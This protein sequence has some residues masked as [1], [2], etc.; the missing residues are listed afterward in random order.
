[1]NSDELTRGKAGTPH[2]F[3]YRIRSA[4]CPIEV[5]GISLE[6]EE[7]RQWAIERVTQAC[8]DYD[9]RFFCDL[10]KGLKKLRSSNLSDARG[11][12]FFLC[13]AYN[14]CDGKPRGY[15]LGKRLSNSRNGCGLWRV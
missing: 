12:K 7:E 6:S 5:F 8:E 2:Y 1:M 15:R 13:R 9:E 14:F 3:A 10:A 4:L 11:P